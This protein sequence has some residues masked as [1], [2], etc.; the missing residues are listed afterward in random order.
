MP[1]EVWQQQRQ[2]EKA[3]TG[4][5]AFAA[6]HFVGS[7]ADSIN[8]AFNDLYYNRMTPQTTLVRLF[9]SC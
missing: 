2:D 3:R 7:E 9:T 1:I 8:S 6:N 5:R 4:L